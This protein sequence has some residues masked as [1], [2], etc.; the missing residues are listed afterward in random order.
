MR[1]KD[2]R[3]AV[4]EEKSGMAGIAAEG[5]PRKVGIVT[6]NDA[7]NYGAFLQEYALQHFLRSRGYEADVIRY[8]NRKFEQEYQYR[9]HLF[10]CGG[11][12]KSLRNLYNILFRPKVYAARC[13]KIRKFL[14]CIRRE[15]VFSKAFEGNEERL[16]DSYDCFIAG[17]DQIWNLSLTGYD[18]YYFLD[19]VRQDE[20]KL[21]YAASLGKTKLDERDTHIL[22]T[23]LKNFQCILVREKSGQEFLDHKCG[24]HSRVTI[25]PTFFM[26]AARWASFA[27][28]SE[29]AKK[30]RAGGERKYV[31]IYVV[32]EPAGLYE[33]ALR[34]ADERGYD[35]N[36][37]GLYRDIIIGERRLHTVID[38]DPYDFVFYILN[39]EAV[40]T[41]SFH[42]TILS[43]QLKRPF[44]YE[45]GNGKKGGDTRI[46]E[47]TER[48]GL[49]NREISS[50]RV[51]DTEINWGYVTKQLDRMTEESKAYLMEALKAPSAGA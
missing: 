11:I 5:R 26:G 46:Q 23:Y 51:E 12:G 41:T 33:T 49:Q 42:G 15:I 19:F 34:Y 1:D 27:G 4:R 18:V 20:K 45:L 9:N 30:Q 35:V 47:I 17:S 6:F 36:V 2:N 7:F 40:F 29:L 43:I 14:A 31:L 50:L 39:A 28:K 25:D 38:A 44:F 3:V 37:L 48:L 10:R 32:A 24:I 21:S 13:R 22:E 8:R 16:E